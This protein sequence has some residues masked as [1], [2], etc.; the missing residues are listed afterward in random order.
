ME[1]KSVK[2][3][4]FRSHPTILLGRDEVRT[5]LSTWGSSTGGRPESPSRVVKLGLSDRGRW[6]R[7][8]GRACEGERQEEREGWCEREEEEERGESEGEG[9]RESVTGNIRRCKFK[10][11]RRVIEGG[12]EDKAGEE[13]DREGG[14]WEYKEGEEEDKEEGWEY[15][16]GK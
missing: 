10:R 12:W 7:E 1:D 16:E 6:C 13:E 14:L 15:K 3:S 8:L 9:A 4:C 11:V 2:H 5:R